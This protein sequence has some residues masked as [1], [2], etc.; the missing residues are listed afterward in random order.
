M[1]EELGQ[2]EQ[3]T[4][5]RTSYAY[6]IASSSDDKNDCPSDEIRIRMAMRE[7]RR[8]LVGEGGDEDKGL[9]AL[10][11]ACSFRKV[12]KNCKPESGYLF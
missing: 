10:Q 9:I 7:A 8:H 5:A 6:W 2:E 4:A 12:S 1:V 3:E 11:Y